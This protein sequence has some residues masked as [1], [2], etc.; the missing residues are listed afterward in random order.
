MTELINLEPRSEKV[1]VML[2]TRSLGQINLISTEPREK[3]V[4]RL[5]AGRDM[6]Y[7]TGLDDYGNTVY[8][9]IDPTV[10]GENGPRWEIG[11]LAIRP[12]ESG[13]IAAARINPRIPQQ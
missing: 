13:K 11:M 10:P 7:F 9:W 4:E 12:A 1:V 5:L 3:L 8:H 2:F 6:I